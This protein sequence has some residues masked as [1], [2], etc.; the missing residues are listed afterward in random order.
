MSRKPSRYRG[1][2]GASAADACPPQLPYP[3]GWFCPAFSQEVRRGQVITRQLAGQDVVLYRTRR[4]TVR[5]TRPYCPHVGAHL[6]GGRVRGKELRC[7]LHHFTFDT[8][9]TCTGTP[10]DRQVPE[11]SVAMMPVREQAG[12]IMVWYHPDGEPPDW[13]VPPLP[14]HG[15]HRPVLRIGTAVT[16]AVGKRDSATRRAA[17]RLISCGVRSLFFMFLHED[18]D[19]WNQRRFV[20]PAPRTVNKPEDDIRGDP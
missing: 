5:A 2:P 16:T 15:T 8:D 3:V 19:V 14:P 17:A 20:A 13:E 11:L 18:A 6:G 4:G 1:I 9:G 10:Y 7:P 12:L